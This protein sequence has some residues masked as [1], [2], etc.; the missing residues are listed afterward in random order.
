MRRGPSSWEVTRC[1]SIQRDMYVYIASR[2]FA[3]FAV[4][5]GLGRKELSALQH[6]SIALQFSLLCL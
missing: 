2:P 6:G 4:W 5:D 3:L 1:S